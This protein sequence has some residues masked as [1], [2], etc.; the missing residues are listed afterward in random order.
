M[1][2]GWHHVGKLGRWR[3]IHDDQQ[4]VLKDSGL[5]T[6]TEQVFEGAVE[7]DAIPLGENPTLFSLW[8]W[9]CE[10]PGH[11]VWYI[12][13]KGASHTTGLLERTTHWW[14]KY[15][16]YFVVG[17]W[18]ECEKA[19]DDHDVCGV[20]WL[21]PD[22]KWVGEVYASTTPFPNFCGNFWWA[23][24]DHIAKVTPYWI[25]T[26]NRHAAEFNFIGQS[27]PK[28]KCLHTSY[29]NLY[30]SAYTPDFYIES[31]LGR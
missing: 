20:E 26:P 19:L 27:E 13:T 30:Q 9:A 23:T 22:M 11:K 17:L 8:E 21:T 29:K 2:Y 5:L 16:E 3:E 14:R 31:G 10:N 28:V 18:R 7:G 4:V 1:I 6:A 12:H 24:T 25:R 15:M